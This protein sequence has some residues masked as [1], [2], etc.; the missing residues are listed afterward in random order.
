[1]RLGERPL[2]RRRAG[3]LRMQLIAPLP[4]SNLPSAIQA[5]VSNAVSPADLQAPSGLSSD[6]MDSSKSI[7]YEQADPNLT[8]SVVALYQGCRAKAIQVDD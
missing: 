3:V 5:G 4:P 1:M 8:V 7:D 2:R 6:V